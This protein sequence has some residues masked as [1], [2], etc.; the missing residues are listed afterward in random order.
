MAPPLQIWAMPMH[1]IPLLAASFGSHRR[2]YISLSQNLGA[3]LLPG[4][5]C[6]WLLPTECRR[7]RGNI[8]PNDRLLAPH[9]ADRSDCEAGRSPSPGPGRNAG[10]TSAYWGATPSAPIT[11][12][13][14]GRGCDAQLP[15]DLRQ[16][17]TA[18]RQ[19]G[20]RLPQLTWRL[21]PSSPSLNI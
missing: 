2:V 4:L 7:R 1:L 8:E 15:C 6:G 17:P 11:P 16:R 5:R 3:T 10:P 21:S 13:A 20:N 14:K 19:Q 12:V 9:A 18:A